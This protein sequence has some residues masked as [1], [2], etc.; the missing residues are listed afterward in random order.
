M[1]CN[2]FIYALQ[3]WAFESIHSAG[4]YVGITIELRKEVGIP[5]IVCWNATSFSTFEQWSKRIFN[6]SSESDG[7]PENLTIRKRLELMEFEVTSLTYQS[8]LR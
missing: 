4:I 3:C 6:V 2:G 5:R 8:A 1:D 7:A